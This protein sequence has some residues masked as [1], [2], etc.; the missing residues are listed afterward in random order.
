MANTAAIARSVALRLNLAEL[1]SGSMV[2]VYLRVERE[3]ARLKPKANG[4]PAH[5]HY[6]CVAYCV[7]GRM[8]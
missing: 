6:D 5:Q 1:P 7:A 2:N 4:G 3:V 8:R